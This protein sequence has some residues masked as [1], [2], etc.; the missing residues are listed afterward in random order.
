MTLKGLLKKNRSYRGF[1]QTPRL[2]RDEL[3]RLVALTR[4]CPSS[5]NVQ[6]L[7]YRLICDDE[8]NARV[9]ALTRWAGRMKTPKLPREGMAPTAYIV[10]L[11][12]TGIAPNPTAFYKDVGIAA[13]AVL[14]GATEM[15]FGGCMLGGY[16]AH[17]LSEALALPQHLRPVLLV[18]LGK[19]AETIVLEDAPPGF[20][21]ADH[22][23][24]RDGNDVHHVWKRTTDELIV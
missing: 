6:P 16:D 12:D 1:L 3:T 10:I 13:L 18:A 22:A 21:D 2:N 20:V 4:L 14:M 19:P 7:K 9:L 11:H 17:A 15:G 23:Y 8:T 5:G 24:Y